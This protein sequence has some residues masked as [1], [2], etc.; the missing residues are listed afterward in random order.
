V[1]GGVGGW[2][3]A[4]RPI[5]ALALAATLALGIATLVYY[6]QYIAPIL[7]RTVPYFLRATTADQSVGLQNRDPFL[8]YLANYWPRMEYLRESGSY[9]LQLGLPLGLLGMFSVHNRR[10]RV[11]FACWLAVALAFLVVGSRISMVDKHVFYL[12]PALA[13]GVG[14]TM[15]RLWRRGPSARL[16]VAGLY[17]FA[18]VAA[19]DMWF[20]RIAAVRQ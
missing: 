4:R 5:V 19:L 10:M 9:G 17:L 12:L 13:L 11:V 15:G 2:W 18:L 16:I 1:G 8:T 6:G 20:Y 3:G 7:E 14:L